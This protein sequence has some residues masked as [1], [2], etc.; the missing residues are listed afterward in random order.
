MNKSGILT[1]VSKFESKK[2]QVLPYTGSIPNGFESQLLFIP[3]YFPSVVTK[4]SNR[5]FVKIGP[6]SRKKNELSTCRTAVP[7]W[8]QI[9]CNLSG[10]SPKR[11]CSPKIVE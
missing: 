6:S 9:T 1:P 2:S 11:D 10:S 5:F 8:T 4:T 7:F 3:N